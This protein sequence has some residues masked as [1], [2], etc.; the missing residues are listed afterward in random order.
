M[1]RLILACTLL[2]GTAAA[3]PC[4]KHCAPDEKHDEVGCCVKVA[5][6]PPVDPHPARVL[7]GVAWKVKL[8]KG[9][10]PGPDGG[11]FEVRPLSASKSRVRTWP[12]GVLHEEEFED[13]RVILEFRESGEVRFVS[14]RPGGLSLYSFV[15]A[16]R[17][18]VI[19][20]P[21]TLVFTSPS[22]AGSLFGSHDP[23]AQMA[24]AIARI[25]R[26]EVVLKAKDAD[27]SV[28]ITL[29]PATAAEISESA[30]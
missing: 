9:A 30:R 26:D 5:T 15:S 3:A 21:P 25:N 10:L 28:E 17:W 14:K 13:G 23:N 19:D 4:H 29:V 11:R 8:L 7:G 6:T 2:C 24:L 20:T 27:G 1:I 22:T 16:D 12:N 18:R